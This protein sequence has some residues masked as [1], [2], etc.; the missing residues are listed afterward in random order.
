MTDTHPDVQDI[1]KRAK[2]GFGR[3]WQTPGYSQLISDAEHLANIL[4]LC[5]M[6]PGKSYLDIGTGSGYV[7]FELARQHPAVSVTGVDIVEQV[8]A[9]DN[10]Q[11][12]ENHDHN[13]RFLNFA[14]TQLPFDDGSFHGAVSRYAF[15]HFPLPDLSAREAYRVLEPG[16]FCVISDPLADERDEVDFINGFGALRDDGHV[17]YSREPVLVELFEKAGFTAE[18]RFR[19]AITFPRA[20]DERYERLLAQTEARVLELYGARVEGEQIYVTLQVMN[21]RFRK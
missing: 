8:I 3:D 6:I 16:G 21:I 17:R 5:D 13:L 4:K 7:A 10:Q 2:E 9:A 14:G 19:S 11:A 12:H 20:M 15:H 1:V 18:R